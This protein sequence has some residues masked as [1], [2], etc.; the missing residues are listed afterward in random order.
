[1]WNKLAKNHIFFINLGKHH[2]VRLSICI[3]GTKC[4]VVQ[5]EGMYSFYVM[6][7]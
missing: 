7:I 6:L 3:Y 1:M 4:C 5:H 2:V